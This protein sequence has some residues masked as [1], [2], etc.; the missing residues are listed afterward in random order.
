MEK[1]GSFIPD[2][3]MLTKTNNSEIF[4]SLCMN[5]IMA[6]IQFDKGDAKLW[7]LKQK[8]IPDFHSSLVKYQTTI[9]PNSRSNSFHFELDF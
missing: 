1:S 6:V 2:F 9:F 7:K 4:H 8:L 3:E 5:E